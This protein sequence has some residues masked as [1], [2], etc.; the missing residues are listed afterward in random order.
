M[1]EDPAYLGFLFSSLDES[2]Q[3]LSNHFPNLEKR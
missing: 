1:K 3:V 2:L